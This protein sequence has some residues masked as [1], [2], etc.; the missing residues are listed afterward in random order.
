MVIFVFDLYDIKGN[1]FE[2]ISNTV[3]LTTIAS[4]QKF[5]IIRNYIVHYVQNKCKVADSP[6]PSASDNTVIGRCDY[7]FFVIL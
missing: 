2:S 5:T 4:Q 7:Y 6:R 3:P 1:F